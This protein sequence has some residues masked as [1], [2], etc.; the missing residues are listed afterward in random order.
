MAFCGWKFIQQ[1]SLQF[2]ISSTTTVPPMLASSSPVSQCY[3]T[4]LEIP[5]VQLGDRWDSHCSQLIQHFFLP[6]LSF[7]FATRAAARGSFLLLNLFHS[8]L[9]FHK[10]RK[11][12]RRRREKSNWERKLDFCIRFK[13]YSVASSEGRRCFSLPYWI[14]ITD[15]S[16]HNTTWLVCIH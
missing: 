13:L 16:M 14:E 15:Q 2:H 10:K 6:S 3:V 1:W 4:L 5:H 8:V 9:T 12:T 7:R 11:G